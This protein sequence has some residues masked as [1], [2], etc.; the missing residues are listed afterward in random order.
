M[1]R[2]IGF[3]LGLVRSFSPAVPQDYTCYCN[4]RP[5]EKGRYQ[6]HFGKKNV[7]FE[8]TQVESG[9]DIDPN[10]G[11][12]RGDLCVYL[13]KDHEARRNPKLHPWDPNARID[14]S[15]RW[16]HPKPRY[17]RFRFWA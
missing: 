7:F 9:Y 5:W 6:K 11:Q 3:I 10:S 15:G 17:Y 2:F 8:P 12:R 14:E 16:H 4:I 1:N 13:H